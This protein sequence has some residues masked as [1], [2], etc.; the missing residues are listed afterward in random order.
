MKLQYSETSTWTYRRLLDFAYERDY[1][2]DGITWESSVSTELSTE[3]ISE[4]RGEKTC[5][6]QAT[7]KRHAGD[8]INTREVQY[9][10]I[11]SSEKTT[12]KKFGHTGLNRFKRLFKLVFKYYLNILYNKKNKNNN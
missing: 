6:K 5:D 11:H 7:S 2:Q 1:S 4:I 12:N 10:A 8:R 3:I 9:L